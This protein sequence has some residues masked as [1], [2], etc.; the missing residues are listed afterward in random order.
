MVYDYHHGKSYVLVGI[1]TFTKEVTRKSGGS[2]LDLT[3]HG[4][5]WWTW[6]D[7]RTILGKGTWGVNR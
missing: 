7:V 3:V 2:M 4:K 5:G 1:R 6:W